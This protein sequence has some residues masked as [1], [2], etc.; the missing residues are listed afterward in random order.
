MTLK[1]LAEN[2]Y[3]ELLAFAESV[4]D[5][6]LPAVPIKIKEKLGTLMSTKEMNPALFVSDLFLF[7]IYMPCFSPFIVPVFLTVTG[8]MKVKMAQLKTDSGSDAKVKTD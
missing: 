1:E 4:K 6:N 8:I 2:A 3:S 7:G 5:D